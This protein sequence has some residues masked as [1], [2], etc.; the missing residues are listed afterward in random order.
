[1]LITRP[2]LEALKKLNPRKGNLMKSFTLKHLAER[3]KQVQELEAALLKWL[4]A[5]Y[6]LW[7]FVRWLFPGWWR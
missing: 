7:E 6:Q 1:V 5:T 4:L 2:G 3:L